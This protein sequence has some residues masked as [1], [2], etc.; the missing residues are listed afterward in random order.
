MPLHYYGAIV[1][2]YINRLGRSA[3][4]MVMHPML[5]MAISRPSLVA[6]IVYPQRICQCI[7]RS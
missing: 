4:A 1:M 5:V 6:I 2:L 3:V 7:G